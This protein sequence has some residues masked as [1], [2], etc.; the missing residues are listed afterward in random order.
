MGVV[1]VLPEQLIL[2]DGLNKPAEQQVAQAVNGRVTTSAP[3]AVG[4]ILGGREQTRSTGW[5]DA[6][7]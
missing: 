4:G 3:K 7:Q 5:Y 1:H 6:P 2:V